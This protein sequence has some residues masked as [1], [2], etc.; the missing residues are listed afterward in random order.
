MNLKTITAITTEPLTL[1]EVKSQIKLDSGSFSDDILTYQALSPASRSAATYTSNGISVAGKIAIVNL[2][3]GT[4]QSTGTISVHIE[5]SDDN[6]TYTDWA[7]GTFAQ[8]TTANDNAVYELQYTGAK[9]YIRVVAV[10]ALAACEFSI[11]IIINSGD[12]SEDALL[13]MWISTAREYGEDYTNHAFAPQTIEYF[14]DDF[15][16]KNF[17]EWPCGPLTSVTSIKYKNSSGTE[18]TMSI[19]EYLVD[20]DT[21]PGRIIL[22]YALYWPTF[23][24]YPVNP[25]TIR[26]TCGYTT[27]PKQYKQAMLMHVGYLY[28]YRD[29]E[30]PVECMKTINALYD[31][32]RVRPI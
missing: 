23:I 16:Y 20:T 30:I 6:I 9:Q 31:I 21:F 25:V 1:A 27:L 4:N 17:I 24:K 12:T 15:P 26:A 3:S 10:V 8:I 7:G 11:D 28:K 29:I 13:S 19:N 14:L 2:N 22:P 32:R 5:E 18:T